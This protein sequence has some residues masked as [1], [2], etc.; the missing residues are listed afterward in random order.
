[1]TSQGRQHPD[2]PLE[3]PPGWFADGADFAAGLAAGVQQ[4]PS[5][6][7]EQA[8]AGIYR[9]LI[10]AGEF[11]TALL[12][13]PEQPGPPYVHT[14]VPPEPIGQDEDGNDIYP[15]PGPAWTLTEGR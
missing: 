12:G 15:P 10:A 6:E 7:L 1:M 4:S 5:R 11:M 14:F 2:G 3:P 13:A 8:F 9:N